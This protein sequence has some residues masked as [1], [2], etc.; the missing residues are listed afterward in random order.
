MLQIR[1][2]TF[3]LEKE[4]SHKIIKLRAQ[5]LLKHTSRMLYILLKNNLWVYFKT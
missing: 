5:F 3:G 1:I 2:L 4:G